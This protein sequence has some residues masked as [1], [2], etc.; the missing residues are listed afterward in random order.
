MITF[1]EHV[2]IVNFSTFKKLI[3]LPDTY[4][5]LRLL[6]KKIKDYESKHDNPNNNMYYKLARYEYNK[7]KKQEKKLMRERKQR[8]QE[9]YSD[10]SFIKVSHKVL[11]AS[12]I[13]IDDLEEM[14][15]DLYLSYTNTK[16]FRKKCKVLAAVLPKFLSI[17]K[18]DKDL[19]LLYKK[20][21]SVY[22]DV[23][24]FLTNNFSYNI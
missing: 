1:S 14:I 3:N 8:I 10:D 13:T 18:G 20:Y 5:K 19:K 7:L 16:L 21:Y 9:K 24:E 12:K 23:N 2:D 22:I 6:D 15:K 17:L 11:S 4:E